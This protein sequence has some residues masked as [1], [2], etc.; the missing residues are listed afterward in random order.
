VGGCS[1]RKQTQPTIEVGQHDNRSKT[2]AKLKPLR[3]RDELKRLIPSPSGILC[4]AFHVLAHSFGSPA[5]IAIS[6]QPD[7]C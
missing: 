2:R 4:H 7:G 1:G 5:A 3:P 6:A